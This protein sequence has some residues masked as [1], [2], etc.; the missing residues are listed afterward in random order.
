MS[1][2]LHYILVK[3]LNLFPLNRQV[4]WTRMED[5]PDLAYSLS[6]SWLGFSDS[7]GC[8]HP[9]VRGAPLGSSLSSAKGG[10]PRPP[11]SQGWAKGLS[12]GD[13][14]ERGFELFQL[15]RPI[16]FSSHL[17]IF[18]CGRPFPPQTT[19]LILFPCSILISISQCYFH[20]ARP[21]F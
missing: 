2:V 18:I 20:N 1:H 14:Q 15:Q 10:C 17:I 16:I 5:I 19:V 11:E 3:L 21:V 8:T 4:K 7:V 6:T 12:L 9:N 13:I